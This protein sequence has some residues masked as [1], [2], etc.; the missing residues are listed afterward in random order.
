MIQKTVLKG[1]IGEAGE[2][3]RSEVPAQHPA[4]VERGYSYRIGP[5]SSGTTTDRGSRPLTTR[6]AF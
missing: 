6:A 1:V 2:R 4:E 3:C 5:P